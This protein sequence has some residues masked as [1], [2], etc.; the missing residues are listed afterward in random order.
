MTSNQDFIYYKCNIHANTYPLYYLYFKQNPPPIL[1][2]ISVTGPTILSD[3]T[4]RHCNPQVSV[5]WY[6]LLDISKTGGT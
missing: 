5:I 6:T 4:G 2:D 1:L 3:R